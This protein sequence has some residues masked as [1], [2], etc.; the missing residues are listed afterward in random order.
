MSRLSKVPRTVPRLRIFLILLATSLAS[1]QTGEN[2]LVVVNKRS[3][4]SKRI[5][6]YYVRKREIPTANVCNI[7]TTEEEAVSRDVY[8]KEI[9]RPV[10]ACIT[11]GGL[12]DKI[13]YIV[14]TL[15]VPLRVDGPGKEMQTEV[16]AVDSELTLLYMKLRGENF[17]LAGPLKN[18][19]FGKMD[20]PFRHPNFA[21]YLVTR[22]AGFDF[23]DVQGLIDRSLVAKDTGNY[24]VDV[25]ADNNTEGNGWLREA[26]SMLP[27]KRLILDDTPKVLYD[28][29]NVIGYASWGF[30]D[31]DRHRRTLGF[32]WLPG[33]IA[34]EFVSNSGRTF[35]RPPQS[36]TLGNWKDTA[37]WFA[38]S[39]QDLSTDFVHEGVTG[40]SAHVWEP[41]LFFC[42]RPN[43]VLPAYASGRN[44][45]ESFYLGIVAL[46]WQNIVIGDPLCKL[47]Q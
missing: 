10:G 9:E 34:T 23:A 12:H 46:S 15:G 40:I 18:G 31:P 29:K 27:P 4:V 47:R 30:N 14:T 35:A 42:P 7:D 26:A 44:L 21:I 33:A 36:W 38:G 24:V 1:A 19:F 41:Y 16:A 3:A 25:R 43:Y 20:V 17:V 11:K 37:T 39:P 13:L 6:Q 32:Q 8:N 28:L 5:G 22:L 2:V 45:A